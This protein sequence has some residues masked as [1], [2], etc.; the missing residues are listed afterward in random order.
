MVKWVTI[1]ELGSYFGGLTGKSKKD[2]ENGNAKFITYMNIYS[3]PSLDTSSVGTVHINP[4]EKQNKIQKGD[5]LFTGSSE[6][7]DESGM[8]CVITEELNEDYYMNSFSFG[9][10]L[11]NPE[12]FNLHYLKHLFRSYN[13]RQEI[14]R[15]AS[16]VTRFNI[17]KARFSK[18]TIPVPLK[19][20][21][22]RI[23]EILDTFTASI[24]NLKE[25]IKER[26]KQFE[27]YRNKLLDNCNN[28]C[29]NI[30]KLGDVCKFQNGFA[31][32]SGSFKDSGLPIV[33]ITNISN[34]SVDLEDCKYFDSNDYIGTN[35]DNYIITKGDI[36]IAMSGATTGKV[37]VYQQKFDAYLNQR[38][39][40]F[41]PNPDV[42]NK[43]FLYHFLLSKT[44]QIYIMAGGGAQP[45][46][47]STKLMTDLSIDIPPLQLQNRI[48]YI[49]DLFEESIINLETQLSERERQYEYYRNKL[50][51]FE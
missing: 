6:T 13:I 34:N 45:N 5:I 40:K 29:G 2:F 30:K 14:A 44:K 51:T 46:L 17:S 28:V 21:Q 11:Y 41:I 32:R 27:Y 38:V 47:S 9:L 12:V 18:I 39:G 36:L 48:V 49:L 22:N 20:E 4:D 7:P 37:G 31:F 1:D 26:R 15:T 25:Q 10:R 24:A 35:L 16:G 43:R 19:E 23:V 8:S 50:L 33:R 42:L 3:N